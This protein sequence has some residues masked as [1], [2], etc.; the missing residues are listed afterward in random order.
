MLEYQI[1]RRLAIVE[2]LRIA[3]AGRR[4]CIKVIALVVGRNLASKIERLEKTY[5]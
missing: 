2:V 3:K 5:A 1:V 4:V